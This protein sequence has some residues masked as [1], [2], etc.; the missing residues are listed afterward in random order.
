MQISREDLY[1]LVSETPLS[2]VAPGLGISA[3]A[4]SAIC[5]EHD[6]PFPGSGHWTRLQLGLPVALP[7][8]PPRSEDS[9]PIEILPKPVRVRSKPHVSVAAAEPIHQ[10]ETG[11]LSSV[12]PPSV[13][14]AER[15]INPHRLVAEWLANHEKETKDALKSRDPWRIR[16]APKAWTP[17]DRRRHRLYDAIFKAIEK[18][19]GAISLGT[20]GTMKATIDGEEIEFLI[21]EKGRQVKISAAERQSSYDRTEL[22]GTGKLVI[23]VRTYLRGSHNEEWRE[24]DRVS[25]EELLPAFLERLIEGAAILKTW[26]RER[27]EESERWRQETARRAETERL[28]KQD[29]KRHEG[30]TNLANQLET[31][32]RLRALMDHVRSRPLESE[33]R[34]GERSVGEWLTWAE[35]HIEQLQKPISTA[36]EL[37]GQIELLKVEKGWSA[38]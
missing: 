31:V 3:T 38:Y 36:E 24:T 28:R 23:S 10:A 1:K 5:R 6:V 13:V 2:K 34:V 19:G 15:L 12:E 25:L 29:E 7:P 11:V 16:F 8:L 37:F 27:E 33:A 9:A 32:R 17:L 35:A 18:R 20:K 22:V 14:V 26:R 4:L 30:L 21:R